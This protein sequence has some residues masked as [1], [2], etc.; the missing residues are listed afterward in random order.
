M[1]APKVKERDWPQKGW[2]WSLPEI[3]LPR[4]SLAGYVPTNIKTRYSRYNYSL[5][6]GQALFMS[7]E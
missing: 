7:N 3:R 5:V 4:S 1:E 2:A 6:I